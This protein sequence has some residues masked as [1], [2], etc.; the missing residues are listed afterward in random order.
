MTTQQNRKPVVVGVDGSPATLDAVRWAGAQAL[1]DDL[2][3]RLV[4]A[5]ELPVGFPTGVT[6][7]ESV[8]TAVRTQGRRWLS[9]A[10]AAATE[11][12][13][14]AR[15]ETALVAA[16]SAAGLLHES[17]DASLVVLGNKGRNM[18]TGLL[19]GSTSL[20][21]AGHAHCPVVL[22]RGTTQAG[23]VVVGVDSTPASEPAV[24]FA[25]AE[26]SA[27]GARL[28]ALH[29]W[30]DSVFDSALAGSNAPVDFDRDRRLAEKALVERLAAWQEKYP[31]VEV[32]RELVHDRPTRALRRR[33][34]T[35]QLLVVAR[36][37]RG[38]FR[39]LVLGST[40]Q[41]V[42]HHATCPVAVVRAETD[43]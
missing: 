39:D 29:A 34:Q 20:A 5:Y 4:H 14:A 18:L 11:V 8:L 36:R 33:A 13:P 37:G 15:V 38:G 3:L 23:P 28:V 1:R 2:P 41:H 27:R 16:S 21:V 10:V 31:Y 9:D 22:A 7:E 24:A 35:A 43:G 12:L 25:F 26:A 32:D 30:T 19:A 40:S 6:E 17:E 42:V